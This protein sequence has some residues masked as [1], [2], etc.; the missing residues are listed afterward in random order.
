MTCETL[1]TIR[2]AFGCFGEPC[3]AEVVSIDSAVHIN[4]DWVKHHVLSLDRN[5]TARASYQFV[6]GFGVRYHPY[7]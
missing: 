3:T 5:E 7:G 2:S 4:R 6:Y 1:W